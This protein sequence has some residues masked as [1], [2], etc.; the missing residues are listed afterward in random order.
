MN[1]FCPRCGALFAP[2]VNMEFSTTQVLCVE[3]GLSLEDPPAYLA[4]SE[5]DDDQIAYEL[6]EWPAE[7]RAIATA[8]LVELGIPYRWEDSL[9]LVVPAGV[10]E[11]VDAILDEIDEN[12]LGS[13]EEALVELETGEDGG[14]EAATAMSDLFIAADGLSHE[15]YDEER[16]VEFIE[17]ASAVAQSL[18]PYG[19][20]PQ[21]WNRIQTDASAIVTAL[22][23][24][25]DGDHNEAVT[26]AARALRDL[27]RNYV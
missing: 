12:A 19:I 15:T 13:D 17:A 25:E 18:P 16:V 10:E 6:A 9:V 24:G 23:K 1:Q 2:D 22:E 5:V 4:P 8:D 20:E 7:D 14:E 21:V 27:L 3:C 11:Q 26:S